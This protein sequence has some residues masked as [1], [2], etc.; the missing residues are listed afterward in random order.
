MASKFGGIAI[1]QPEVSAPLVGS[2]S[3]FGGE[4]LLETPFFQAPQE[5]ALTGVFEQ[6][7]QPVSAIARGL[8]EG[9]T[10]GLGQAVLEKG[11]TQ[12]RFDPASPQ[13]TDPYT[14]GISEIIGS[15]APVGRITQAALKGKAL[16]TGAMQG[17]KAVVAAAPN[18]IK[19]G[20]LTGLGYGAAGG[21]AEAL[22]KD[23]GALD[24]LIS[25]SVGGAKG[26]VIG[27]VT[28]GL[29]NKAQ[30]G[31]LDPTE[32]FLAFVKPKVGSKSQTEAINFTDSGKL[33]QA[34]GSVKNFFK[35]PKNI[36]TEQ[37]RD[38][39]QQTGEKLFAQ[40]DDIAARFPAH[41]LLGARL[42]Q[43]L[44]KEV[45]DSP[46]LK[47]LSPGTQKEL[48][49][50]A[51]EIGTDRT[52]KEAIALQKKLNVRFKNTIKS[53]NSGG[54]PKLNDELLFLDT[55]RRENSKLIDDAITGLTGISDNPYR[56]W[57][58][59]NELENIIEARF[60]SLRNIAVQNKQKGLGGKLK[61]IKNLD[62]KGNEMKSADNLISNLF[63]KIPEYQIN[64]LLP[65][66][67]NQRLA[68]SVQAPLPP[69]PAPVQLTPNQVLNQRMAQ[70][71]DQARGVR[72][73]PQVPINPAHVPGPIMGTTPVNLPASLQTPGFAPPS[74]QNL[75]TFIQNLLEQQ[76]AERAAQQAASNVGIF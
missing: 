66:V 16:L 46:I 59:V 44:Q 28:G 72:P 76:A 37:A 41:R 13:F 54:D 24:Q 61:D 58:A 56:R 33:Q 67:A 75:Q 57:G 71:I 19:T 26:M 38:L 42:Q 69:A 62:F 27:G 65:S 1:Q 53:R 31:R 45:L 55:L 64:P 11:I 73:T 20:A 23:E 32:T 63:N 5:T 25:T 30:S 14:F 52:L 2:L 47:A 40:V 12:D 15:F 18:L 35:I 36:T 39:A 8:L 48:T 50:A 60:G 68:R 17:G 34:V 21:E 7:S 4:P 74:A 3:R 29:I 49:E 6:E 43:G 10:A 70:L 51:S 22:R 9:A